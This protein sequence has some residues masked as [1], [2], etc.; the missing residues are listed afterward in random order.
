MGQYLSNTTSKTGNIRGNRSVL[1][2]HP[3]IPLAIS[4]QYNELLQLQETYASVDAQGNT[5]LHGLFTATNSTEGHAKILHHLYSTLDNDDDAFLEF[6]KTKNQLGCTTVWIGVAYQSITLLDK[7][8]ECIGKETVKSLLSTP[9]NQGDTGILAACSRGGEMSLEWIR[10]LY[11]DDEGGLVELLSRRNK[12][13]TDVVQTAVAGRHVTTLKILVDL[14][15][16]ERFGEANTTGLYPLHVAAERD[17]KEALE[18]LLEVVGTEGMLVRDKNGATPL[19]V[20]AFVGAKECIRAMVDR[21]L[22]KE[23][24]DGEGRTAKDLA[25]IKKHNE[26]VA[27]LT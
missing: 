15:P 19:H 17:C 9:N 4:G 18:V 10:G 3:A 6:V 22:D 20:A 14:I 11:G 2:P 1:S 27:M 12:N 16:K 8:V 23:V 5:V 21:G 26:I 7:L 13:G 24:T 25:E